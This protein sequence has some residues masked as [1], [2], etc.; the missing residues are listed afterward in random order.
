[1]KNKK[2]RDLEQANVSGTPENEAI[3]Q[4]IQPA[5]AEPA[6]AEIPQVD[7]PLKDAAA[8]EMPAENKPADSAEADPAADEVAALKAQLAE[9]EQALQKAREEVKSGKQQQSRAS[10]DIAESRKTIAAQ[11]KQV[12]LAEKAEKKQKKQA[13]AAK[14]KEDRQQELERRKAALKHTQAELSDRLKQLLSGDIKEMK[15]REKTRAAEIMAV[16]AKH[17]FYANGFTPIEMRTTLEDLGPTY[18]KIGQI[19]SSRVDLLPVA[20]CK[21]LENLRANVKELDP[22]IARAVIEQETGQKIEDLFLEFRD[23][24]MGSASIGQAHYAVL[25]DGTKVVA[26]VQRPLIADMMRQD[27]VLLKK[28]AKIINTVGE[29]D[30]DSSQMIDLLSVIE[31]LEKVEEE[32]LDFRVEA[33]N[34]RFFKENCIGDDERITCPT[35]IDELTTERLFTRTFVD[36]YSI[37]KRDRLIEEGYDPEQIGSVILDNYLHQVLDVGTFHGDP[38]QGNIMV[39]HGKPVWIDFG[40]IGRITDADVNQLQ[41]LILSLIE[42]DM[43]TMVNTIMSLGATSPQ[44]DRNK[45]AEDADVMMNKYMNVTNLNEL[46]LTTLLG[47]VT[48]LASKHHISLPG[49]FTML[50]RSI[51]TIEGVIEQLCPELNLFEQIT[52][53][54]MERVKKNFD[55]SQE[56][57]STGKDALEMGKKVSRMPLL[58]YDALN[59]AVKGRLKLNFELTGYESIMKD[60]NDTVMNVVL[61]L[62][63]CVLFIGSCLL[64]ST[65]IQPQTVSGQPLIA[66][67]GLLV[68]IALGIYTIRKMAKKRKK[69]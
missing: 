15:H 36:G 51:A 5:E 29:A 19:M 62:F 12:R 38:H 21:E 53:R 16:F 10:R 55:L 4:D 33:E 35:V 61:A 32:E 52:D 9:T 45:L 28:L 49:K 26:K 43:D 68:S 27:F 54:F 48:D 11:K 60:L 23:K 40:M 6:A 44:T 31:E 66:A 1:M 57:L 34:T 63:S 65:D 20:Y 41:S 42:K 24:P 64:S 25:K 39:S 59:N 46:D 69:K 37:S 50:V 58:A 2:D 8:P 18:V 17:N 56:L 47:E 30:E 22:E 13:A 3:E 14:S 7:A 67:I